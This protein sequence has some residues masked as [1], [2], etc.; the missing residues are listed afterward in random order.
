VGGAIGLANLDIMEREH[1]VENSDELG[2]YFLRRLTDRVGDHPYVGNIEGAGLML[3]V[4]FVAD[5]KTKRFFAPKTNHHR[6]VS[7]KA[8]EQ[9]VLTRAL[10]F[11]EV[12][13]F[14]PPLCINRADIDES[15]ERYARALEAATPEL[16]E[17]AQK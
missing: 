15:I 17:L 3:A 1:L 11:V 10:P 2:R 8:I 12:N 14:S 5:K 7:R 6:I 9:G 13:S 16:R 4:E